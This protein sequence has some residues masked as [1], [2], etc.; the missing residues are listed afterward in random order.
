MQRQ[1]WPNSSPQLLNRAPGSRRVRCLLGTCATWAF[2]T[3]SASGSSEKSR[4]PSSSPSHPGVLCTEA[5]YIQD[6]CLKKPPGGD[7]DA[8][9]EPCWGVPQPPPRSLLLRREP[10]PCFDA[11]LHAAVL[12]H[13]RS[14]RSC[15]ISLLLYVKTRKVFK[16]L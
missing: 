8:L 4:Q 7:G 13:R 14:H 12:T 1:P 16:Y 15:C 2:A 10:P 11:T 3:V 5:G 9:A 6:G